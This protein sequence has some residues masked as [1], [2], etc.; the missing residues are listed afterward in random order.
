MS[1]GLFASRERALELGLPRYVPESD[2]DKL[3]Q[4][5]VADRLRQS[6]NAKI[7][8]PLLILGFVLQGIGNWPT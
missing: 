8:L 5:Q 3:R 7:G 2:D 6:M 1:L 4:P